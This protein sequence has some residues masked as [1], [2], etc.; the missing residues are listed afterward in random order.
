[1]ELEIHF[2]LCLVNIFDEAGDL[3]LNPLSIHGNNKILTKSVFFKQT[4]LTNNKV[5]VKVSLQILSQS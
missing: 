2:F 1:M 4:I 5:K 3:N